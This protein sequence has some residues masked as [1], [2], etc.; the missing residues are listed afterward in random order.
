MSAGA[1][2]NN[3][4]ALP[5]KIKEVL[6]SLQSMNLPFSLD[7]H[8]REYNI[9]IIG[10]AVTSVAQTTRSSQIGT[11]GG[12][13]NQNPAATV[14]EVKEENNNVVNQQTAADSTSNVPKKRFRS[15]LEDSSES[16]AEDVKNLPLPFPFI[17]RPKQD[18][19]GEEEA[20]T[21]SQNLDDIR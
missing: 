7:I 3:A 17:K 5:A 12:L 1:N 21:T 19:D 14:G 13:W 16:E 11:L 2:T 10:G 8:E 6:Q 18:S 4:D 20:A 15:R 9:R